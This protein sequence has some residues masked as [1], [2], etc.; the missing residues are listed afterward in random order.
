MKLAVLVL[1][2]V[3]LGLLSKAFSGCFKSAPPAHAKAIAT[4]EGHKEWVLAVSL[5]RMARP[6]PRGVRTKPSS[7]GFADV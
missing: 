4:L 2:P 7:F 3:S 6:W 1:L 5:A